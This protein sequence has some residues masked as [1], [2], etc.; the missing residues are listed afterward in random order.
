MF[1]LISEL[2]S[3]HKGIED[4][5]IPLINL[6]PDSL[7]TKVAEHDVPHDN[8]VTNGSSNEIEIINID[9]QSRKS[10]NLKNMK[11]EEED[12]IANADSSSVIS[13]APYSLYNASNNNA[14]QTLSAGVHLPEELNLFYLDP[15][16]NIQGPFLGL[17]IISWF[18][19]GFFGTD[20]P[21][22]LLGAPEGMPFLPLGDVM[23]HLKVGL[24]GNS[25][26][27]LGEG[28]EC[29]YNT[30]GSGDGS[31]SAAHAIGYL[32]AD[33]QQ[34]VQLWDS[35]RP[36]KPDVTEVETSRYLNKDKVLFPSSDMTLGTVGGEGYLFH[37]SPGQDAEGMFFCICFCF[38][39][40]CSSLCL[41]CICSIV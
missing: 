23:P 15:Q 8:S 16:G 13:N 28:S 11:S 10:D 7:T 34:Q 39:K 9:K 41:L 35:L 40:F 4:T 21:V 3:N 29:L 25:T 14:K 12:S 5:N 18:E 30:K 37:D 33:D 19:Q 6:V 22:C 1:I 26:A 27:C 2:N 17:D 38:T 36:V 20:L 31:V 32:P 24:H